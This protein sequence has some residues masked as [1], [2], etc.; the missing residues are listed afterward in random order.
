MRTVLQVF[1]LKITHEGVKR[2]PFFDYRN[3]EQPLLAWEGYDNDPPPSEGQ[4]KSTV[5]KWWDKNI[6]SADGWTHCADFEY[7]ESEPHDF[8]K[9]FP[10]RTFH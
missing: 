9:I 4:D 7:Y 5:Q 2:L 8:I 3:D 1:E 6:S 10:E